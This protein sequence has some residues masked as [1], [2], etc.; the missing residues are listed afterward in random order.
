MPSDKGYVIDSC[1]L[2]DLQRRRYPP[3]VFPT[4]WENINLLVTQEKLKSHREVLKELKQNDDELLTWANN[5]KEI[6]G[7]PN[8]EQQ[9]RV[10]EILNDFS[11]LVDSNKMGPQ[12]DPFVIARALCEDMAVVTSETEGSAEHPKIPYVCKAKGVKC[13]S[14]L[15][16]FRELK[17]HF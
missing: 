8:E 1:A 17:W 12:A 7:D 11:K 16:M 9:S 6:F 3:D 2:I 14:L 13:M 5:H 4:L 15:E 10:K